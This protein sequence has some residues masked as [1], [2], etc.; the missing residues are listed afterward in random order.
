MQTAITEFIV[1]SINNKK[2]TIFS[3]IT[4]KNFDKAYFQTTRTVKNPT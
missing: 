1:M 3:G 4:V 2:E